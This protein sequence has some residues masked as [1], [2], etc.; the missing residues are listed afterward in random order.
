M[1]E[2]KTACVNVQAGAVPARLS[3]LIDISQLTHNTHTLAWLTNIPVP[4]RC[5]KY[6]LLNHRR[7]NHLGERDNMIDCSSNVNITPPLTH[8]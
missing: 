3:F 1:T 6:N 4:P 5:L 2:L 8:V 7:P